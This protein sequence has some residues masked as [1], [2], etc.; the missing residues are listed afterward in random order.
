LNVIFRADGNREI[1]MGHIVRCLALADGLRDSESLLEI[2]FI[3]RHEEGKR[4]I[5]ERS[6]RVIAA[7]DDEI[8]RIGSLADKETLLITD[9]LDTDFAYISR[10]KEITNLK[11][12]C[13][14]N[15]THLKKIDADVVIN[16]NVF[17]KDE[18]KTIGLTRYYLGPKY[19]ILR[20]EFELAHQEGKKI[21]DNVGTI[22][23]VSGGAD[24]SGHS[25][26]LDSVRALNK[27]GEEVDIH[28]IVGPAFPYK[29]Q[30]N[31]LLSKTNR[32]F[33]VS[34]N[35]PNLVDIMK[36]ADIAI[37]A[38]GITLYELATLGIPPIA[39]PQVTPKTN[40]QEDIA[41]AFERHGACLNLGHIPSSELIYEKTM[42]LMEDKSLREYLSGN[43]KAL[44]DGEG[45]GRAISLT[46]EL[47]HQVG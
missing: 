8:A 1:G 46:S 44:V 36:S 12:I 39:V 34:C 47:S 6:Y 13:I 40:H 24:F 45:L 7:G 27:I 28:L 29:N 4:A 31:G 9:F 14:D 26:I 38:A 42:M 20:K 30:L 10:I 37:T 35:P 43:G 33:Y 23:V 22:L 11:L 3:T 32:H 2:L 16:A 25:L 18:T 41:S 17:D 15:N 19:M 21:E 5:E